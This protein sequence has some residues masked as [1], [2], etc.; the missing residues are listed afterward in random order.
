MELEV[1][2]EEIRTQVIAKLGEQKGEM[3]SLL[4]KLNGTMETLPTVMEGETLQAYLSEYD[5]IVSQIYS[6]LNGSL[7][8]F[9][10]QLES[11]CK[12]FE[13]LDKNMRDQLS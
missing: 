10:E 9:V 2:Y 12:E 6:N 8:Q 5:T 7:G 1:L 13:E 4:E 3:E 11:V